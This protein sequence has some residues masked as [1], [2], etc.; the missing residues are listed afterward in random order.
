MQC[1]DAGDSTTHTRTASRT[2]YSTLSP[3]L[4]LSLTQPRIILYGTTE[5]V[6]RSHDM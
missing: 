4:P 2:A 5:Y 3:F 6:A 1:S